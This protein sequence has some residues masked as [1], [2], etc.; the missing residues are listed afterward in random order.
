MFPC[1]PFWGTPVSQ[2]TSENKT[3]ESIFPTHYIAWEGE[4]GPELEPGMSDPE[5]LL[6]VSVSEL[7]PGV[8][9]G[10]QM[11][12]L[13]RSCLMSKVASMVW[14]PSVWR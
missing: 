2:I 11:P 1:C 14:L 7:Y 8:I 5:I 9:Y 12:T 10:A 13:L 4:A 6:S 3:E